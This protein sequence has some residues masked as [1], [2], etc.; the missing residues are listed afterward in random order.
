M[1]QSAYSSASTDAFRV[2]N[3]YPPLHLN[4]RTDVVISQ[5]IQRI[6]NSREIGVLQN[7]DFEMARKP[8]EVVKIDWSL[9]A[10]NQAFG[11]V[12]YTDGLKIKN[13]I[14][15]AFVHF[16]S[17]DEIYSELFRLSDEATVFMSETDGQRAYGKNHRRINNSQSFMDKCKQVEETALWFGECAWNILWSNCHCRSHYG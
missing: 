7:F 14:D 12:I 6:K 1:Q 10:E 2:L 16:Q 3:D 5:H 8:W 17:N 9:F 13:R 11:N 4:V 15:C